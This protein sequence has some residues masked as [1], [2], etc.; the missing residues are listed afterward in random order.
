LKTCIVQYLIIFYCFE[1]VAQSLP[2]PKQ[3]SP[4]GASGQAGQASA[5]ESNFYYGTHIKAQTPADESVYERSILTF[6]ISLVKHTNGSRLWQQLHNYPLIGIRFV[7]SRFQK[8]QILGN[9]YGILP[10]AGITILKKPHFILRGNFGTGLAYLDKT[11]DNDTINNLISSHINNITS[12]GIKADWAIFRKTHLLA[13]FSFTHYS[14]GALKQPNSGINFHAIG[15]G[16]KY[17]LSEPVKHFQKDTLPPL[18]KKLLFGLRLGIGIADRSIEEARYPVYLSSFFISKM[19]SHKNRLTSGFDLHYNTHIYDLNVEK[20]VL[21]EK[22][23]RL[24][25]IQLALVLGEEFIFRK[26]GLVGQ[27]GLYLYSPVVKIAPFYER[28]GV[29][30]YFF[31]PY[32]K[33]RMQIFTAFYLKAHYFQADYLELVMGVVF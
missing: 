29:Q 27:L 6:D 4:T 5:I 9:A 26:I 10:F 23:R 17:L 30:Y 15:L 32:E 21:P 16:I 12:F 31:N 19:L 28:I 11:Y 14:N 8:P 7:H 3:V 1:V 24:K 18:N 20:G 13:F 2:S 25:S 22:E 33:Q